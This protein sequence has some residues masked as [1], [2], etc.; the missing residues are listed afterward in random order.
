[1][2]TVLSITIPFFA[3]IFLGTFF[4]YRNFFDNQGS[5]IL[6]KFALFVTLPPFLFL[7]IINSSDKISF[8]F[9]FIFRYEICTILI[10]SFSYILSKFILFNNSKES[11]IFSLNC[12]YPNYGYM[13]I[14]LC[15]LAFG[16]SSSIPISM[17]LIADS[18]VLLF[19]TS[20]FASYKKNDIF[21]KDTLINLIKNPILLSVFFG[22]IFIIF[23]IKL[24]KLIY[25]FL[26]ILSP[27][28]PP[29]ALFA[30]GLTLLNKFEPKFI[31][32]VSIISFFKLLVHPLLVFSIFYIFPS[33]IPALW[34]KVAIL[35][36]SLSVAA[37]VFAMAGYYN[38]FIKETS[39]SIMI[40]TIF[41]TFSIPLV[42]FLLLK[43]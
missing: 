14:P 29:T 11:S 4:K 3:I 12:A 27:A 1:M 30:L 23:D 39:N 28:A 7:N 32:P 25:D 15:I 34:I 35:C 10:L 26:T 20:Y 8:Q 37:N 38:V 36:S 42:L 31:I 2:Q 43:H 18:L 22:F 16:E 40:T 33:S 17:I 41:S 21:F 6:T 24:N 19:F 5:R 13:G 9:D